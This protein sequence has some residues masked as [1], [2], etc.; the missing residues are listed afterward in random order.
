MP[1]SEVSNET[2]GRES[3]DNRVN[4]SAPPIT[5]DYIKR[6]YGQPSIP[7]PRALARER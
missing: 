5:S 1:P 7:R 4:H 6:F 3:T 2:L